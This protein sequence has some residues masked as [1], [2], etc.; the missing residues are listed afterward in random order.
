MNRSSL[1]LIFFIGIGTFKMFSILIDSNVLQSL[2][3]TFAS[4]PAPSPFYRISKDWTGR[5][6]GTFIKCTF[7]NMADRVV[8]WDFE[9]RSSVAGPHRRNVT[10]LHMFALSR[11]ENLGPAG[12]ARLR[13]M[14]EFHFCRLNS[15][16]EQVCGGLPRKVSL[17]TKVGTG[18]NQSK[19]I[20][21][22]C[23]S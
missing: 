7:D 9:R 23:G 3:N 6:D 12:T 14:I 15:W 10:F 16:G 18:L 17:E 8:E 22:L 21:H 4:S 5:A 11:R 20:S 19:G 2:S 13:K 1:I